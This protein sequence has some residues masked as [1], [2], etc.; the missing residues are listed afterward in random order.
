MAVGVSVGGGEFGLTD[1]VDGG[2]V[3]GGLG[4]GQFTAVDHLTTIN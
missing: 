4:G 2:E 1:V 3:D